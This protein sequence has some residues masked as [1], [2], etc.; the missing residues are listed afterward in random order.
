[1]DEAEEDA[2]AAKRAAEELFEPGAVAEEL[3]EGAEEAEDAS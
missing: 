1:M 3:V 2:K